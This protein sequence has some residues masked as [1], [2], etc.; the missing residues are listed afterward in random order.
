M[1]K[2]KVELSRA[3][4]ATEIFSFVITKFRHAYHYNDDYSLRGRRLCPYKASTGLLFQIVSIYSQNCQPPLLLMLSSTFSP[5]PSALSPSFLYYT[6][7]THTLNSKAQTMFK[8]I[9]RIP[10]PF[11]PR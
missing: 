3:W 7:Y 9:R 8:R 4:A 11:P 6:N 1:I 10:P 2:Q 5:F